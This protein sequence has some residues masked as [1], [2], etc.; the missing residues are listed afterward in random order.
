MPNRNIYNNMA[1]C[2]VKIIIINLFILVF[3]CKSIFATVDVVI[4][5]QDGIILASDGRVAILDT[6]TTNPQKTIASDTYE[7]TAKLCNNIAIQQ[8]GRVLLD[9]LIL[10]GMINDFR[11][12]YGIGYDSEIHLDSVIILF[13]HYFDEFIHKKADLTNYWLRIAGISK[14]GEFECFNYYPQKNHKL[15]E[16]DVGIFVWGADLLINR[17]FY[18]IDI[19]LKH[20][21]LDLMANK[22]DSI[23]NKNQ[24]ANIEKVI[25]NYRIQINVD[26]WSINDAIQY[27]YSIIR[28]IIEVDKMTLCRYNL[29]DNIAEPTKGGNILIGLLDQNGFRWIIP[30]EYS[31]EWPAKFLN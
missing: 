8:H 3:C 2:I 30:P 10:K 22:E 23:I 5:L 9:G 1:L 15:Q 12:K 13:K 6:T 27:A 29:S 25:A 16:L 26:S 14:S 28:F 19:G 4:K 18:G 20:E 31:V 11:I 17:I 7:K 24:L 21:L